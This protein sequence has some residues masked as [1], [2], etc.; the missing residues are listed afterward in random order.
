MMDAP[1]NNQCTLCS[2]LSADLK[3]K[4]WKFAPFNIAFI[5]AFDPL[6]IDDDMTIQN[7]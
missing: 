3:L 2:L 6:A 5:E 1:T 4:T 7:R